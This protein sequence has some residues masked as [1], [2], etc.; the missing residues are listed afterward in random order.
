M[1]FTPEC[2]DEDKQVNSDLN[3]VDPAALNNKGCIARRLHSFLLLY[4]LP[5]HE[6]H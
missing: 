4:L 3:E 2:V 1:F 6:M 5:E